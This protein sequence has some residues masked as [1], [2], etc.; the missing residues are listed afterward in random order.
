MLSAA[1]GLTAEDV[2]EYDGSDDIY[3]DDDDE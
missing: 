2:G 3:D 1:L